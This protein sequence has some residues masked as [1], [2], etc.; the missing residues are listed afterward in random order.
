MTRCLVIE[1]SGEDRNRTVDLLQDLGF[2][3][4]GSRTM[5]EAIGAIEASVPEVILV[6]QHGDARETSATLMRLRAAAR[7][8]GKDPLILM[9]SETADPAAIGA[10]IV[11]GASECLIKPFDGAIL[12]N[13]L[14]QCGLV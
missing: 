8:R 2:D 3:V 13:K 10:A 4:A 1:T 11:H 14:K 12:Q 5:D 9:C 6:E 7:R